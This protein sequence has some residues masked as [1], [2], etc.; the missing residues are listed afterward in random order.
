MPTARP[1]RAAGRALARAGRLHLVTAFD[2]A[3][4]TASLF[5]G[6]TSSLANDGP[7]LGTVRGE[8]TA[9]ELLGEAGC[10]NVEIKRDVADI[11]NSCYIARK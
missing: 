10:G 7:G 5:H 4:Y 11:L 9:P 2:P 3:L 8:Q 6:M 1:L